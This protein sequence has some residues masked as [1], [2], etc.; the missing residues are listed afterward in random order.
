M[1]KLNSDFG[2]ERDARM[3]NGEIQELNGELNRLWKMQD[4]LY[5]RYAAHWGL[6]DTA[7]WI[8]YELCAGDEV[9]TQ[10]RLAEMWPLP[11]QSIN[12]AVGALVR[13]GYIVLEQLAMA[14][15]N[16]A[17]RLTEAGTAFCRQVIYPFYEM[18]ERVLSGMTGEE[19]RIFLELSTRQCELLRQE[20]EGCI[21]STDSHPKLGGS[22]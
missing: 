6:S 15:N 12:S 5:H 10:N 18:E 7:F 22:R 21:R 3:K 14:R 1:E 19:R 4:S 11:R 8:L 13:A 2:K 9:Y 17:L 20:V 16:K